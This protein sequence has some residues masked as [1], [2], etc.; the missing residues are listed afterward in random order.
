MT[1]ADKLKTYLAFSV[2][3]KNSCKHD[4]TFLNTLINHNVFNQ[5]DRDIGLLHPIQFTALSKQNLLSQDNYEQF[6]ATK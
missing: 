5:L 3:V 6:F 4:L 1:N 2:F